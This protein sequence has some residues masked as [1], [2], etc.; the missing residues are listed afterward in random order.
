MKLRFL[1]TGDAAGV[2]VHGCHCAACVAA[3]N[4][5]EHVRRPC[6]AL[7]ECSA[8]HFLIDAG[9]MDLVERFPDQALNAMF[10][11]HFHVDHVQGL[12]RLRWGTGPT[13]SVYCPPDTN[14]CADLYKHP[15]MLRFK[16]LQKYRAIEIGSLRV[17]PLPLIHS[18]PTLGYCFDDGT[19]RLAYLTDTL[20]LPPKVIDFLSRRRPHQM[21]I[22]TRNPP[23]T[24]IGNHNDLDQTLALHRQI[25]PQ[26]TWITHLGHEMDCWL[27]AGGAAQLPINVRVARDNLT[28]GG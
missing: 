20:G 22:D 21:V 16:P 3:H 15:G 11:T 12:F 6:S 4:K 27:A 14:G 26:Q 19:H 18:K 23:G 5:P 25:A 1:G 9:L 7:L 13:I 28:T 2:P 17:T 8:G 10:L 24:V